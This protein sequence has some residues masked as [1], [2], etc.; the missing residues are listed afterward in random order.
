MDISTDAL[1]ADELLHLAL[2][3]GLE[4]R[5][6]RAITL[7]KQSW[8]IDPGNAVTLYC[9]GAEHAQIGLYERA[10]SEM[11]RAVEM[12]PALDTAR[13]QLGLLCMTC[14]YPD[15]GEA[16]LKPLVDR[17]DTDALGH[18]ARGLIALA[19]DELQQCM[20]S[21]EQ[22]IGLNMENEPLNHDMARLLESVRAG[23][24]GAGAQP[25]EPAA[26]TAPGTAA[27]SAAP[28]EPAAE[29]TSNLWMSSYR[30]AGGSR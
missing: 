19:H 3:A 4:G 30:K 28:G 18:F 14:G 23:V 27:N 22:G 6:D 24:A 9:L 21:L 11:E 10:M 16:A 5:H 15:R 1:D 13:L 7:L 12:N 29:P 17:D 2:A 8:A 26:L 25:A 20:R